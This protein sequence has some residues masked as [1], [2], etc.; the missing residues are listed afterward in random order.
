[1]RDTLVKFIASI[2]SPNPQVLTNSKVNDQTLHIN[3]KNK[4]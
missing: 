4:R 3:L 2:Q 1:M